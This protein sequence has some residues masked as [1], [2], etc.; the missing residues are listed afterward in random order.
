MIELL[1]GVVDRGAEMHA[2]RVHANLN[3][4]FNWCVQRAIL[5]SNPMAALPK[6]TQDRD[7]DRVFADDELARIWRAAKEIGYPFGDVV[8]LLM[9]TSA[10]RSKIGDH[11]CE[12]IDFD[13]AEVRLPAAR[14]K[15]GQPHVIPL[16]PETVEILKGLPRIPDRETREAIFCFTTAGYSPISGWSRSKSYLDARASNINAAGEALA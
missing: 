9:L 5:K 8:R 13:V 1:D 6:P 3:R 10:R 4:L 12:A 2:R 16:A 15:S 14:T 11:K 7:R